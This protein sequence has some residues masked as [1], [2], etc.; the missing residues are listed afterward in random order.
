MVSLLSGAALAKP[1]THKPAPK[2]AH[3]QTMK[4]YEGTLKSIDA[5]SVVIEDHGKSESYFFGKNYTP[6]PKLKTGSR[7]RLEVDKDNR[8]ASVQ[9]LQK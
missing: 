8:V 5:K 9:S 4:S 1:A 6:N 7:V 2:P 3:T